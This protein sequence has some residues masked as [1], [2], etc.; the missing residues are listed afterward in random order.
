MI[1]PASKNTGIA[2]TRPV[3]PSAQA[4]FLS[5]NHFTML[6]AS[7]CAPPDASRMTPNMEPSPTSNAIPFN[8]LPMPSFT[9]V[10]IFSKG[11]PAPRPIT[12]APIRMETIACTLNLMINKSNTASPMIAARTNL[13][14]FNSNASPA[15]MCTSSILLYSFSKFDAGRNAPSPQINLKSASHSLHLHFT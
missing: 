14:G 1:S 13:V 15:I 10:T 9:A 7:V 3:I 2:M 6:T 5:P 12:I 4:A 8:V 11:M